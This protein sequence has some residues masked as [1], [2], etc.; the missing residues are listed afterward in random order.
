[1]SLLRGA[2]V[3]TLSNVASAAVPFLLLPALTHA[4]G[5]EEYGQ[6]AMF[7][8]LVTIASAV[9]GLSVHGSVS[10]RFFDREMKDFSV[11]VSSCMAV[12]LA[13]LAGGTLLLLAVLAIAPDLAGVPL[14][15]ALGALGVAAANF[16]LQM[17]LVIWLAQK[18]ALQYA[19]L[20]VSYAV[21]NAGLTVSMVLVL[22]GGAAGRMGAQ[23][24]AMALAALGAVA[25]LA[26][27]R[28]LAG[29]ISFA[30]M[31][32]AAR[33]GAPLVPHLLG[34]MVLVT[35]D[36][37]VI[38]DNLGLADTGI[39]M[40]AVQIA[41]AIALVADAINKAFVPWL[42]EQLEL[43]R[44]EFPRWI[45]KRTWLCF[46]AIAV[47]ALLAMLMVEPLVRLVA[48]EKYLAATTVLP[49]LIA[50]QAFG[51]AYFLVANYIFY[52]QRTYYLA[53]A[54]LTAGVCN[55]ALTLLLVPRLGMVGAGI[56]FC[57]AQTLLFALVWWC[58]NRVYP[59]PWLFWR[60]TCSG[61]VA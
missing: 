47:L 6:V 40:V 20:Q 55:A 33:F 37:F 13:S 28:M 43:A 61:C 11:Y 5:P 10:V 58:S 46:A 29:R 21:L 31:K 49:W 36:R 27:S 50:G 53:F 3:Y 23:V 44:P 51:T 38:R 39:Y 2:A 54:S 18:R 42:Y 34:T 32:E 17:R 19:A 35:F 8:T 14:P 26:C 57:C 4:M 15:W 7:A 22:Q 45:V 56:S 30:Y 59:M 16:I 41:L 12:M 25:S 48:G 1:M 24:L 9:V 52:S 60:Q